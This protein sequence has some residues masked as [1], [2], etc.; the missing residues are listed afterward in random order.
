MKYLILILLET[1]IFHFTVKTQEILSGVKRELTVKDFIAAEI[2][3]NV[4]TD[5]NKE[6]IK[7]VNLVIDKINQ[8]RKENLKEDT[9][10]PI[11][12]KELISLLNGQ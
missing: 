5:K 9:N 1:I 3:K 6:T 7:N 12:E 10:L 11:Y 4:I 2:L 8:S